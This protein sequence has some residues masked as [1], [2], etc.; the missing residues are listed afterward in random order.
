MI[1]EIQLSVPIY[2]LKKLEFSQIERDFYLHQASLCQDAVK[3]QLA[4]MDPN[5]KL[6]ELPQTVRLFVLN[7][8]LKLRQ[9]C[10]HPR[11]CFPP[12]LSARQFNSL[13]DVLDKMLQ[14]L[15]VNAIK[16]HRDYIAA[17]IG[18]AGILILQVIIVLP[19]R[20]LAI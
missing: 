1:N 10:C 2:S 16:A 19:K 20:N 15:K 14:D 12:T 17:V 18:T 6:S 7:H 3:G 8:A 13:Q 9:T 4:R 11:I 5:R